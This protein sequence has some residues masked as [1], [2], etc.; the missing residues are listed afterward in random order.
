MEECRASKKQMQ[1]E[2]VAASAAMAGDAARS[3]FWLLV[4]TR[5]GGAAFWQG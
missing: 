5:E 3:Q 4:G 1:C 2:A